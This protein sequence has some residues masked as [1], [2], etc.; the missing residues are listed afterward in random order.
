[1]VKEVHVEVGCGPAQV[2]YGGLQGG[3]DQG[4]V[5]E[6]ISQL[7]RQICCANSLTITSKA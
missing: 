3:V 7:K 2:G 1:M 6:R 4:L 5:Q